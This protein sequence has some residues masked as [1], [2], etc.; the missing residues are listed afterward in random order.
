[1]KTIH[2][3]WKHW[4]T[5]KFL[6]ERLS[7]ILARCP[8]TIEVAARRARLPCVKVEAWPES[9]S[10]WD[11]RCLSC[12]CKAKA[13]S[14][15]AK[16]ASLKTERSTQCFS[17]SI[18]LNVVAAAE[19]TWYLSILPRCQK[20]PPDCLSYQRMQ[21]CCRKQSPNPRPVQFNSV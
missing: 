3:R 11:C 12:L 20:R 10:N 21:R 15:Y 17:L 16:V 6:T 18:E 5:C 2:Y 13:S 19:S 14:L 4:L 7:S 1:M 8:L 9:M